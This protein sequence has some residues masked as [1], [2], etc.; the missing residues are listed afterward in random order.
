MYDKWTW[1][2]DRS[3]LSSISVFRHE[4]SKPTLI[5]STSQCPQHI[6]QLPLAFHF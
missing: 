4:P 2:K 1:I 3:N 5:R 6:G